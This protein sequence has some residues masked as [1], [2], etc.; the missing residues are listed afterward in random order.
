MD[1]DRPST[2]VKYR[3]GLCEGCWAG[4]CRMPVEVKAADLVRLG[5]ADSF[6]IEEDEALVARKL[7]KEKRIRSYRASTGL[8]QLERR[9]DGSCHLL[10]E[11]NLCSIYEKRPEVC[12]KFPTEMGN[13]PGF[14][15][16]RK[17]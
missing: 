6:E 5:W 2:W 1:L 17:G 14:C 4:C 16:A 7:I 12:R 10:G 15:P 13:R 9:P 3:T 8:F 11:K